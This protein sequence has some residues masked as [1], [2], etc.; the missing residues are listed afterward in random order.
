M[1]NVKDWHTDKIIDRAVKSLKTRQFDVLSFKKR[2]DLVRAILQQVM[3]GMTVG[4]GGS[5]GL[6]E[7][8]L[9]DLLKEKGVLLL[10]TWQEG[11]TSQEVLDLRLRQLTCDL[12]LS[13]INALTEKGEIVNMDGIGNRIGAITFGPGKVILVAGVNKIVPDIESAL[14]RIKRVAAPMNAR[15]MG[16]PLPCAETGHCHD[17]QSDMRICRVLSIMERRP[18]TTDITIY[19]VAEELGY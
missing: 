18:S 11:L 12:F 10:D 7:L 16:L 5:V 15:R 3:P 1:E 19:L 13:G 8:G 2:E 6:R 9:P 14:Q 17:C 4:L